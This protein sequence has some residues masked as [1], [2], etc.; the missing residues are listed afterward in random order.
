MFIEVRGNLMNEY[1]TWKY[2]VVQVIFWRMKK[3]YI[4]ITMK[5]CHKLQFCF[6]LNN[7]FFVVVFFSELTGRLAVYFSRFE[8]DI[9]AS[10]DKIWKTIY[11]VTVNDIPVP[12]VGLSKLDQA[13]FSPRLSTLT[14]M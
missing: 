3:R 14:G 12:V 6:S 9:T 10:G 13:M 5:H 4:E 8:E 7:L 11:F 2:V 1:F